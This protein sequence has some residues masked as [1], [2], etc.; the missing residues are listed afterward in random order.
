MAKELSQP[1]Q[2][3]ISAWMDSELSPADAEV[4]ARR[5]ETDP[6]WSQAYRRL[7]AL[8]RTLGLWDVPTPPADLADRVLDYAKRKPETT[9]LRVGRWLLSAAAVALIGLGLSLHFAQKRNATQHPV[10]YAQS[11]LAGIPE[12][13]IR[14]N[15]ELFHD[16]P[17]TIPANGP[18][19]IVIPRPDGSTTQPAI[20]V[21]N[22]NQLTPRQ[23]NTVRRRAVI[24]LKLTPEQQMQ[25]VRAHERALRTAKLHRQ[26]QMCRLKTVIESFTPEQREKL[27]HMTPAQ[28]SEV[29]LQRRN[30]LLQA[31]KLTPNNDTSPFHS[32][33]TKALSPE[34]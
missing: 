5:V 19:R 24:F 18:V 32:A 13:F 28:R 25:L 27:L 17:E 7:Q 16:M 11:G 26:R 10:H 4:V 2:E 21:L 1:D 34:P 20:R 15:A 23:Q 14:E 33:P 30:E 22:W 29:F 9:V 31:G 12:S 6:D 8:D 3:R